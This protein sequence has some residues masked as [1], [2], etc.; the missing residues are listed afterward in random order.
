MKKLL[1]INPNSNT[2]DIALLVARLGIGTLM[3]THGLPK[4]AM[5]FSGEPVQF[6]PVM[7]MSVQLSLSLAVF[8]EV[9]CSLLVISGFATRL[10]VIPLVVTML[11]ALISIHAADVFTKQ[12]PALYYLLVYVVLLIAGSGKYSV[13][14]LLQGKMSVKKYTNMKA[15]DRRIAV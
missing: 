1:S 9:F 7:G 13:D 3:L 8:A 6:P 2:T 12:E 10:A 4:L 11:V 14:Y 5:L 15:E